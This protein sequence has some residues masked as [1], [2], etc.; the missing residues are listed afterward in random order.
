MTMKKNLLF[1]LC[2]P[3]LAAL[4]ALVI[5]IFTGPRDRE[6]EAMKRY[7]VYQEYDSMVQAGLASDDL[8]CMKA[9][10]KYYKQDRSIP[11]MVP[12]HDKIISID[13]QV[14][15][16]KG[17]LSDSVVEIAYFYKTTSGVDRVYEGYLHTSVIHERP[18]SERN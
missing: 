5:G 8:E 1:V 15:I 4:I 18:S 17:Q 16:L 7:Y 6:I 10:G 13:G 12:C 2:L 9:I 11:G 3:F 14:A